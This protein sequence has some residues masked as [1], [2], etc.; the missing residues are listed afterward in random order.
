MNNYTFLD[1]LNVLCND[2]LENKDK[3][4]ICITGKSGVG[5]S[6]LGKYIRK[7]GFGD[8]SKYMISVID[9]GVMSMDLLYIFNKRVKIKTTQ[10]DELYPFIK[11]L[12]KRKKLIF[13]IATDPLSKISF[14]DIVMHVE[15]KDE[16]ERLNRLI[17]RDKEINDSH[18]VDSIECI[19][20]LDYKKFI[21][22]KL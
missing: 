17:N 5:K 16:K 2:L 4:L 7:N 19:K 8:F 15:L 12:P 18:Y 10:E 11:L 1:E 6:T 14:A 20:N 21:S 22:V 9:D 13:C 3:L